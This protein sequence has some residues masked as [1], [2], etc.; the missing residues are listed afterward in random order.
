MEKT[1]FQDLKSLLQVA[2]SLSFPQI[3]HILSHFASNEL[4]SRGMLSE[5]LK[6]LREESQRGES[7][8]ETSLHDLCFPVT[9][10]I[11]S[12]PISSCSPVRT[13]EEES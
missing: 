11:E 4:N 5:K 1:S 9:I 10:E 2:P 12:D 3:F 7:N 6:E 8:Q 13:Q